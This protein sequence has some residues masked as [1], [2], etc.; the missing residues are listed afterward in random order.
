MTEALTISSGRSPVKC[1][2]TSPSSRAGRT[3]I[4]VTCAA[5][6]AFSC[7][8]TARVT[9][10]FAAARSTGSTPRTCLIAPDS[11]S[12]PSTAVPPSAP[13]GIRPSAP[14]IPIA[15]ARSKHPPLFF[16]SA[17]ARFTVI[18]CSSSS[19][20]TCW[21]AARTRTRL[22]RTLASGSPTR[23]NCAMPR[24]ESTSTRTGCGSSPTSEKLSTVACM[25]DP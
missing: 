16:T 2:S 12:S 15:I 5:S 11:D 10:C 14:R 22:S 6:A 4:P 7:G 24:L 1:A 17:G 18:T 21:S 20:P 3:S 25:S 9:P 19:T 8:T 23:L 13:S